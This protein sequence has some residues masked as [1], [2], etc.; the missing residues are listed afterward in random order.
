MRWGDDLG[1]PKCDHIYDHKRGAEGDLTQTE[2]RHQPKN[3]SKEPILPESPH[4]EHGPADTLPLAKG[5]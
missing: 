5:Y 3:A 1:G 4:K 2:V